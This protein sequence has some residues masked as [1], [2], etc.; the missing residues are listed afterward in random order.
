[1]GK[2]SYRPF[3]TDRLTDL[4]LQV[5]SSA[6]DVF[7][8]HDVDFSLDAALK[9]AEFEETLS[10]SSTFYLFDDFRWPFYDPQDAWKVGKVLETMG[11]RIGIH[12][13]ER[14][15]ETPEDLQCLFLMQVSFHCPTE[16]QLWRDQSDWFE[17]A[18]APKWKGN[19]V[20]DSLGS[21]RFE[22]PEDMLADREYLQINLHPEW[23]WEPN[24]LANVSFEEHKK[25]FYTGHPYDY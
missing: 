5:E 22:D 6:C 20:A 7:W 19:Y 8:R 13:D 15:I 3:N 12:V 25:Y 16:R 4:Y 23:W 14:W 10:V 2:V 1:M 17:S 18:Y 9:M 24:W 11:H 21:F